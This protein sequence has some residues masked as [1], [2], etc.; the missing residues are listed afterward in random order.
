MLLGLSSVNIIDAIG[1]FVI[2]YK[3]TRARWGKWGKK[4]GKK[5]QKIDT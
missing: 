4:I 5:E 3:S 2:R 1:D